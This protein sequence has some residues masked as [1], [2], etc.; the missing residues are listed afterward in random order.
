MYQE[1]KERILILFLIIIIGAALGNM[2]YQYLYSD[3]E[4]VE[5]E[6]KSQVDNSKEIPDYQTESNRQQEKIIVHLGGEVVKSGVYECEKGSR[7]YKVLKKAGGP[8]NKADLNAIN[9]A[10]EVHDGEKIII[11]SLVNSN[12]EEDSKI[13]INRAKKSDLEEISGV[14][15]VTAQKIVDYREKNGRFKELSSL[16]EVSGIGPKT[17]EKIEGEIT[18]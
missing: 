5:V 15:P 10:L 1:R 14:G 2:F 7:I 12:S 6:A 11:P 17:L 3:K 13:N 8:T 16:S 18:H 4:G 9:L